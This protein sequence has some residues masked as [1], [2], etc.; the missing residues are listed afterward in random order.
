MT[1]NK[2]E[3]YIWLYRKLPSSELK[4]HRIYKAVPYVDGRQM[5]PGGW[6][7]MDSDMYSKWHKEKRK[8]YVAQWHRE[9]REKKS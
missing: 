8:D 1:E 5:R 4:N 9:K 7:Y 6:S 2:K 3:K